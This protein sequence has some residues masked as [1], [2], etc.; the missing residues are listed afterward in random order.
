MKKAES[1]KHGFKYYSKRIQLEEWIPLG[2]MIQDD[3]PIWSKSTY[4]LSK[5][6]ED[7]SLFFSRE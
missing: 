1:A 7:E 3:Q 6:H 5:T 4:I 2:E